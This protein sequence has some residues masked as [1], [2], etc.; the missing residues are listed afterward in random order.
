MHS[1]AMGSSFGKN[2]ETSYGWSRNLPQPAK[3]FRLSQLHKLR[4]CQKV[5][6]VCY[7]RRGQG[8][9]FLLVRT[10]EGERWTFPKG[11]AEPGLTHAQAAALEAFEEA[12]VHGRMEEVQFTQYLHHK[13]GDR[14]KNGARSRQ[15]EIA[16]RAHLC[17]VLRLSAPQEFDR[18]PT[19]FSAEKAKLCL[20]EDRA[21]DFGRELA[22]VID[23]A[24]ARIEGRRVT[25][26]VI[27][28]TQIIV[29]SIQ[30]MGLDEAKFELPE[31]QVLKRDALQKVH[32]IDDAPRIP[33]RPKS[34]GRAV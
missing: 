5:A 27:E 6:A 22:R 26:P 23:R 11:S 10:R 17:E 2:G 16:V 9:E 13:R 15:K 7:R 21:R 4:K 24:V 14:R 34:G 32:F 20:R 3:F 30:R 25:G 28:G 31:P 8:I 1:A 18:R 29:S 12:G 19:W 33:R